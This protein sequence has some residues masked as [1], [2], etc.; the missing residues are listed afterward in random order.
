MCIRDSIIPSMEAIPSWFC[1]YTCPSFASIRTACS[2]QI[3]ATLVAT[4][5]NIAMLQCSFFIECSVALTTI[6]DANV[7]TVARAQ[8]MLTV[9]PKLCFIC[10]LYTSD[11]A[12][13]RS[14]VDLGGRRIIK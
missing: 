2:S 5:E 14:S 12:D 7:A 8:T 6:D 10:L 4:F 11:A 13:E 9:H 3:C 1:S